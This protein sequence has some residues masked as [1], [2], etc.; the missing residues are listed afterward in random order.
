MSIRTMKFMVSAAI[1]IPGAAL[2]F[3]HFGGLATIGIL[4]AMWGNNI[5]LDAQNGEGSQK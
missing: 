4:L 5:M 1:G 3:W 2:M